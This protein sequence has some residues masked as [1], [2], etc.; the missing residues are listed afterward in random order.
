MAFVYNVYDGSISV[1][2]M[3]V[4]SPS[5]GN[6][7]IAAICE[8]PPGVFGMDANE[9]ANGQALPD[10]DCTLHFITELGSLARKRILIGPRDGENYT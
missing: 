2:A 8:T 5:N 4:D 1:D 3:M 7:M 6:V 9:C 10:S